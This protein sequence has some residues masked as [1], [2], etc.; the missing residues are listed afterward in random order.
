MNQQHTTINN[1]TFKLN[2]TLF[3]T[4]VIVSLIAYVIWAMSQATTAAYTSEE[5]FIKYVDGQFEKNQTFQMSGVERTEYEYGEPISFAVDYSTCNYDSVAAFRD[6]KI[7]NIKTAY[8]DGLEPENDQQK[9]LLLKTDVTATEMGAVNLMI[10][11]RST[12][13]VED[14]MITADKTIHTYQFS[15]K[16]GKQL[17]P[18]Q[19]LNPDYKEQCSEYFYDYF[20]TNY[21]EEQLSS[22]WKLYIEP[23]EENFN[24]FIV[25]DTGVSFFFDEG[26]I[27]ERSEGIV[28]AGIASVLADD[29]VRKKILNR[30]ID[31]N[32][33]M[34]A[35]TYDDGPGFQS[36]D[37]ILDCLE[38]YDAV[39]TFFYQGAFISGREDKIVRARKLGCEIGNHTWNHPILT[40]LTAAELNAQ[41]VKTNEAIKA[42]CGK[43]PTVFRPS[44]GETNAKV[45]A[46][47]GMPVI[48]WNIDTLDWKSRDGN[49]VFNHV[50]R[51]KNLDGAIILMHS[52]HDS[53]A[54]ATEKIIPWLKEHGYQ[55]VTVS[56]LIK[57]KTGA[58]P[59][60]GK[61]YRTYK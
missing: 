42:A 53:T 22:D 20:K 3:I 19:I 14:E 17:V 41:V 35:I 9:A 8:V 13:E 56:E 7:D 26:T 36:E 10:F 1:N 51:S 34:V 30:Y 38:K 33:P 21:S 32:K 48:L 60:P 58:D 52:I 46:A 5:E 23:S 11:E 54:D 61:V 12:V 29:I 6:V 16:T 44:Y 31:P 2:R 50:A 47:F 55:L 57:Y 39:A 25:T 37:R 18:Q 15:S 40:D 27:L 49:K 59:V 45:N 43:Y 4:L 24:K 28:H